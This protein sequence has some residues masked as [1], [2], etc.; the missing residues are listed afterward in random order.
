MQTV[1]PLECTLLVVR[2]SAHFALVRAVSR[3]MRAAVAELDVPLVV[4][5]CQIKSAREAFPRSTEMTVNG[6]CEPELLRGMLKVTFLISEKQA[7]V[8]ALDAPRVAVRA[9]SAEIT[10]TVARRLVDLELHA[11]DLTDDTCAALAQCAAL[12]VLRV[13]HSRFGSLELPHITAL[14]VSHARRVPLLDMPNLQRLRARKCVFRENWFRCLWP[15]G[16]LRPEGPTSPEGRES[17]RQRQALPRL[18][19]LDVRGARVADYAGIR[20]FRLA[21]L[22]I[23]E[24]LLPW[25]QRE[26][27]TQKIDVCLADGAHWTFGP[28]ARYEVTRAHLRDVEKLCFDRKLEREF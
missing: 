13:P 6:T 5:P 22:D 24:A 25:S 4:S 19:H 14:D 3:Y 16:P 26:E 17:Q 15:D 10:L 8:P 2:A 12:R 9:G 27:R 21:Y 20:A 23:G 11:T 28:S 18:T 7:T 1:L